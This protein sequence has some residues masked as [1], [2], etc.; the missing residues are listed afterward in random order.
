MSVGV[1][2]PWGEEEGM[3]ELGE[4]NLNLCEGR[5]YALMN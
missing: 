3:V 4:H 2:A 1:S 5:S